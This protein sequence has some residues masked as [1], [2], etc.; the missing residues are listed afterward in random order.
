MVTREVGVGP[1][2][3]RSTSCKISR[4]VTKRQVNNGYIFMVN[5][6]YIICVLAGRKVFR[7]LFY[8]ETHG[9]LFYTRLTRYRVNCKC[10]D[11][12]FGLTR[13][14]QSGFTL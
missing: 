11:I 7:Y 9:F 10:W 6:W 12:M 3:L 4:V 2:A 1:L 8:T 5:L 14:W 13:C